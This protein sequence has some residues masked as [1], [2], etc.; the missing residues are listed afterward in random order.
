MLN[1]HQSPPPYPLHPPAPQAVS[2]TPQSS[3]PFKPLLLNTAQLA[4][5]S[6]KHNT[7]NGIVF[8]NSARLFGMD[9]LMKDGSEGTL[10]VEQ[11]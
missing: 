8:A 1:K 6:N 4:G 9:W 5:L 3:R 11:C 2:H 10:P 7:I